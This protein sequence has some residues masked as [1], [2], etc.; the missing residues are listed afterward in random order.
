LD[1]P[2]SGLDPAQ[3]VEIRQLVRE[4]AEGDTTVMLSTHVIPEVEA[5]CNRVIIINEG[6]IVTEGN[7]SDLAVARSEIKVR[8]ARPTPALVQAFSSVQGVESVDD[9]GDGLFRLAVSADVREAVAAVA[10]GGGLLELQSQHALE[11]VFL[12]LTR[13]EP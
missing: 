13:G 10:V 3:R 5:I 11:E 8:L 2:A 12:D 6:R 1:E 7:V 4:L 9:R